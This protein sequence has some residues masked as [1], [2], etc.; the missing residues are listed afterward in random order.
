MARISLH[1]N[2]H[3]AASNR[4]LDSAAPPAMPFGTF[5]PC[6]STH[7]PQPQ[8]HSLG[9]RVRLDFFAH[10]DLEGR[11]LSASRMASVPSKLPA[12][13]TRFVGGEAGF[14]RA[15][16]LLRGRRLW[17]WPGPGGAA[18]TGLDLRLAWAKAGGFPD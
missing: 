2:P 15:A 6:C 18:K 13:L 17:T 12:P 9:G 8:G 11:R 7:L 3:S 16:G 4:T 10:G 1:L 5:S 14:A